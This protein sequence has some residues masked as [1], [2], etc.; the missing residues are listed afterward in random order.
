MAISNEEAVE[1]ARKYGLSMSDAAAIKAMASDVKEAEK[2]AG[3]HADREP[4]V[5]EAALLKA[6]TEPKGLNG[7]L[8]AYG[9]GVNSL[10]VASFVTAVNHARDLRTIQWQLEDYEKRH[11]P[12]KA[13]SPVLAA[14]AKQAAALGGQLVVGRV[15]PM[16]AGPTEAFR[17][18]E[19]RQAGGHGQS[20]SGGGFF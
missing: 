20:A 17:I 15:R 18:W 11:G 5:L 6:V 9:T 13:D 14:A 19:I 2:L 7:T 1:I 12:L 4:D 8:D 10:E 3:L 16:N